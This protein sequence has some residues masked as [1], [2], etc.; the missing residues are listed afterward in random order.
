M[1]TGLSNNLKLHGMTTVAMNKYSIFSLA[2]T[3]LDGIAETALPTINQKGVG[4]K[5][6]NVDQSLIILLTRATGYL[7][8]SILANSINSPKVGLLHCIAIRSLS[9]IASHPK[10]INHGGDLTKQY[11]GM[12]SSDWQQLGSSVDIIIHAAALVDHIRPYAFLRTA[13]ALLTKKMIQLALPYH[14][15]IHYVS[16]AGFGR[17][18]GRPTCPEMTVADQLPPGDI[19]GYTA[20][21]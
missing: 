19:D 4:F 12:S 11:F 3:S 7:V 20:S 15:L 13:N 14:I 17:I 18:V 1:L 21:K 8:R 16:A 5:D 2:G 10:V 9:R 6:V